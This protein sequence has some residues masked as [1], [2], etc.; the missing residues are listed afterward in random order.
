VFVCPIIGALKEPFAFGFQPV[1]DSGE[2]N[3][4]QPSS[5][6]SQEAMVNS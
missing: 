2:E 6:A 1:C 5:E 4:E 3:V